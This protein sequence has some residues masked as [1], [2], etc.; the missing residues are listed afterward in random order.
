MENLGKAIEIAGSVVDYALNFEEKKQVL[1]RK[2][3]Q[4]ES[5]EADII[6]ELENSESWSGKKRKNEVANWLSNVAQM[7]REVQSI[8]EVIAQGGWSILL[9]KN[10]EKKTEELNELLDQR[11]RFQGAL[12][13]DVQ[14]DGGDQLLAPKLVGQAFQTNFSE[15][16]ECLVMDEFSII[17]I[18]GMGGVGKTALVTHIHNELLLRNRNVYWTSVSQDLSISKLQNRVAKTI[19]F[20]LSNEDDEKKRAAKLSKALSKRPEFV[21]I[22]DDLWIHFPLEKVG[23]PVGANGC[24]LIL[25]TRSLDVCW[26]MGCQKKFKVEPLSEKESWNL[27]EEK[28]GEAVLEE[29]KPIAKSIVRECAGLPL[30][31]VT[32][33]GSMRGVSDVYEWRNA[34]RELQESILWQGDMEYEVFR[35][36]KFSYNRL[37]D[38]ALQQCFL[39]CA[40]YPEDHK[41][42]RVELIEYL[43]V[44]GI[45]EGGSREAEID[46]GH[47]ILNRLEKVCLLESVVEQGGRCV[48]MHDLVRD[49]A[50]QIMKV[51]PRVMVKAGKQLFEMPN[52]RNWAEDLVRVSL[53]YN[54]I[55]EIPSGYSPRCPQLSTLLLCGN[56][57]RSIADSFFVQL[58]G[59]KVLDLSYTRIEQ[60][61]VFISHLVNLSALLLRGCSRLRHMP[62]LAQLTALKKLDMHYTKVKHVPQGIELLFNLEYLDL[63][64][65]EIKE[66]PTGILPNLFSLQVLILDQVKAVE[67][68]SLRKLERLEC[69]VY[70]VDELNAYTTSTHTSNLIQYYLLVAQHK[71]PDNLLPRGLKVVYFDNCSI[72]GDEDAILLP[73]DV[74]CLDFFQCD[75]KRR[76]LCLKNATEPRSFTIASCNGIECLFSLSSSPSIFQSLEDMY[77]SDLKDLHFLFGR[78]AAM[79]SPPAKFM[80]LSPPLGTFSLLKKFSMWGCPSIKKLFPPGLSSN[81]QK[82]E[83][84]SVHYCKNI[85]ELIAME[86]QQE[87]HKSKG[88]IHFPLPKLQSISLSYLPE[89]KSICSGKMIC[90]SLCR[91]YVDSCLKLKRMP[92]SLL[93]LDN[94]Q[95]SPLPSLQNIKIFPQ[96]WWETVELDHPNAK[97]VLLPLCHFKRY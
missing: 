34:L 62:S 57:L 30:G 32:I 53:M 88:I 96:E 35:I 48:K 2:L 44:E 93:V 74:Q 16:K 28:I 50:I 58:H 95:L 39:Y 31:I 54:H 3:K 25:T 46:M 41:I 10:L 67:I 92:L 21:L 59:L 89:L 26:R 82:L 60:L 63:S 69:R 43:I 36:L 47:T 12:V 22:L 42:K 83:D 8:E 17:G 37:I 86:E 55:E 40:L 73:K 23:I 20:D 19:G 75:I 77:I 11:N 52:W 97:N 33:A 9:G 56:K 51:D 49:M 84:I 85:E 18:Y 65:T 79:A 87:S 45:I 27:F 70:D 91:I 64:N 68:A 7:K 1:E 38:S 24:K 72:D 6:V 66:L 78:E 76:S 14:E 90:N 4:L 5:V 61:P 15:I 71:P 13:L 80:P 81:L 29:V 94:D